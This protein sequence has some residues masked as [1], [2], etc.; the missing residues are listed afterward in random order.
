MKITNYGLQFDAEQYLS[1]MKMSDDAL[2]D[3]I[4]YFQEA[5]EP[6]I[7]V[8]F[9]DHQPHLSDY[10]YNSVMGRPPEEFTRE[11]S[12]QRYM[13]PFLIWANYDI[14]EME[15]ECTSINY[16]SA[17]M[18]ETAGLQLTDYQRFLMDMNQY[19]PAVSANGYYDQH[20]ELHDW[21]ERD[22]DQESGK[23][24]EEYEILQYN[25][26]FDKENRLDEHYEILKKQ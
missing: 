14:G 17:L 4:G 26:L 13:V 6:T 3:L 22:S 21:S 16:L 23:W 18:M 8:L 11:Q 10:F 19:V 15:L 12:V 7:I 1:L 9:G 25:Y 2:R 24:L 5:E 20:G